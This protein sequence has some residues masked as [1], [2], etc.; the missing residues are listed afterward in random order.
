MVI[1]VYEGE[2]RIGS[3]AEKVFGS[4]NAAEA[5]RAGGAILRA[6]PH[7]KDL[8]KVSKGTVVLVPEVAGLSPKRQPVSRNA[9]T[10]FASVLAAVK[11][12]QSDL[13]V[14]AREQIARGQQ[15]LKVIES[16]KDIDLKP[17]V[18]RVTRATKNRLQD[19]ETRVRVAAAAAEKL[20][21][22][23]KELARRLP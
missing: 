14:T 6:N 2:K 23:L 20:V 22:G 5:N 19:A 12:F 7:L 21:D 16:V 17:E 9:Q 8:T 3:I 10:V 15:D 11:Q 13:E 18:D 1:T 4:L